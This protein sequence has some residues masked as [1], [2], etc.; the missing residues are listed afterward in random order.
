V[1]L[2]RELARALKKWTYQ[3]PTR[4]GGREIHMPPPDI[5]RPVLDALLA[6]LAGQKALKV[7][8]IEAL[9]QQVGDPGLVWMTALDWIQQLMSEED[10]L[11]TI[12]EVLR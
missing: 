7:H 5:R 8:R 4:V 12:E 1:V 2:E 6:C 10:L 3:E 11:A 9:C